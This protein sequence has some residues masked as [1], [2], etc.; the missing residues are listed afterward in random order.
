MSADGPPPLLG[1]NSGV[2]WPGVWPEQPTTLY[3]SELGIAKLVRP[4][5]KVLSDALNG[6]PLCG[7]EH[8]GERSQKA[9]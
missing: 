5:A 9:L 4:F 7:F 6:P 8:G 1:L 3:R 2:F